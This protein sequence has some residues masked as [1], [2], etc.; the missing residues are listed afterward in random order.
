MLG[1]TKVDTTEKGGVRLQSKNNKWY[2]YTAQVQMLVFAVMHL[3]L[4]MYFAFVSSEYANHP[5]FTAKIEGHR[6][7]DQICAIVCFVLF[8]LGLRSFLGLRKTKKI[9]ALYYVYMAVS[10]VLPFVYLF[11]SANYVV[12]AMMGLLNESIAIEGQADTNEIVF[13]AGIEFGAWANGGDITTESEI[14]LDY[15]SKIGEEAYAWVNLAD[16]NFGGLIK[17]FRIDMYSWNKFEL[18]AIIN[19]VVTVAFVVCGF[20][21]LPLKKSEKLAKVFKK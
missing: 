12:D 13:W 14:I 16:F 1:K 9:S 20:V 4:G 15:L 17:L 18:F 10:A 11:M 7:L 21:F 2:R 8:V 3:V 5:G 6:N 19:A